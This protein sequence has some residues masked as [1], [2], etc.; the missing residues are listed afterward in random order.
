MSLVL[1]VV[2]LAMWIRVLWEMNSHSINRTFLHVYLVR[3]AA[4]LFLFALILIV[5][6]VYRF[7]NS[8]TEPPFALAAS[9]SFLHHLFFKFF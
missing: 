2:V 3:Q 7:I 9:K 8:M 4:A 1:C 6:F 5:M